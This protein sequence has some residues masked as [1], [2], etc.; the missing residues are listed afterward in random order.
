MVLYFPFKTKKVILVQAAGVMVRG[1]FSNHVF[2][3]LLLGYYLNTIEKKIAQTPKL[4][5]LISAAGIVSACLEADRVALEPLGCLRLL[6]EVELSSS[7][8]HRL[9][10]LLPLVYT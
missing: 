2:L 3:L 6:S 4:S 10:A 5:R 9:Q 7:A 8:E 1:L